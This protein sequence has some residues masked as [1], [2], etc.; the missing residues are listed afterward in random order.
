MKVPAERWHEVTAMALAAYHASIQ[1]IAELAAEGW[2]CLSIDYRTSPR[3]RW[4]RHLTD[5]KTAIAWIT[6]ER[7][8]SGSPIPMNTM[9]FT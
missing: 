2:V 8:S 9:F 6:F 1:K 4:P 3:H 7:L 5:V